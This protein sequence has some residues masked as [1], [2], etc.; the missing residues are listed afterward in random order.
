MFNNWISRQSGVDVATTDGNWLESPQ[1]VII[2]DTLPSHNWG[3]CEDTHSLFIDDE[4]IVV[5]AA[6][7]LPLTGCV[8]NRFMKVP[9]RTFCSLKRRDKGDEPRY[10][11][12][13]IVCLT[14]RNRQP[15]IGQSSS[16]DSH[17]DRWKCHSN[18]EFWCYW[19][20]HRCSDQEMCL[21]ASCAACRRLDFHQQGLRA[22]AG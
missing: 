6:I 14:A 12:I 19:Q 15:R 17:S 2:T 3:T 4:G 5:L 18:L 20:N 13:K 22:I 9:P 7:F 8:P 11:F 16:T 1:L 10:I 21:H